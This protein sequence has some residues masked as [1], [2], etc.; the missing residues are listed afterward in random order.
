MNERIKIFANIVDQITEEGNHYAHTLYFWKT[1]L[2][3]RWKHGTS[4]CFPEQ[5]LR[6]RDQ[7]PF[8]Y[9]WVT[10]TGGFFDQICLAVMATA[11]R[12]GYAALHPHTKGKRFTILQLDENDHDTIRDHKGQYTLSGYIRC[13]CQ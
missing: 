8:L 13:N 9:L 10:C 2:H 1:N 12:Y 3:D 5:R 4:H 7:L 11:Q 6:K